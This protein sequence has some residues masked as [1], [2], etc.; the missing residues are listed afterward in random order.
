MSQAD[1][2]TAERILTLWSAG[3]FASTAQFFDTHVVHVIGEAFPESGVFH[4]V[5]GMTEYLRRFLAQW[6]Q[7]SIESKRLRTAGDSVLAD[8]IQHSRGKKSGIETELP[9]FV[10]FT[11]RGG[12]IVRT[13]FF[14]DEREAVDAVGLQEQNLE[15]D[16]R[17]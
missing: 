6:E 8:V 7:Y 14:L 4:G 5:A 9:A 16:T 17:N 13:E 15:L 11:F 1:L 12:R 2:E 3:D 10:A